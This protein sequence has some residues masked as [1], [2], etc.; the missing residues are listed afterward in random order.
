MKLLSFTVSNFRSFKEAQTLE[1][2][3]PVVALFGANASGKT[4]FLEAISYALAAVRL[5]ATSWQDTHLHP[6]PPHSPFGLSREFYNQPSRFEFE[7][8][9]KDKRYLYGFEYSR[10]GVH[11]EWLSYV[12]KSRWTPCFERG[13]DDKGNIEI[14]W[15]NSYMTKTQQKD[16]GKI[17]SRELIFSG[18]LRT[19]HPVLGP[20]AS[21][22]AYSVHTL[23]IISEEGR[24]EGLKEIANL[25]RSKIFHPDEVSL[26]L[27]AADTGIVEVSVD[28]KRIPQEIL[29][30]FKAAIQI[31]DS[32]Q[33]ES[34]ED[35]LSNSELKDVIYNLVFHHKGV[36]GTTYRLGINDES[37]GTLA[38]LTFAP[39]FISTLREGGVLIADELDATLHIQLLEMIVQSFTDRSIN[40][41]GAQLIITAHNTNLMEHLR[42]LNIQEVGIW[43]AEKSSTGETEIYSL[44]DFS[45]RKEANYEKR[46]LSGRYGAI[47]SLSPSIIRGLVGEKG[48]LN[49]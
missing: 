5:S 22:L 3:S 29:E 30:R 42:D 38:W 47:P 15:N 12:P 48:G 11:G 8:T 44:A 34:S 9:H 4:N 23:P 28:E 26:L 39:K 6:Q 20:L 46:Y 36:N 49:G 14:K 31:F 2:A 33:E 7:F 1:F 13:I 41:H 10:K 43:F 45:N 25:I 19:K 32:S 24:R 27:Q 16:L 35:D 17:N 18:A 21:L 37:D 40:T